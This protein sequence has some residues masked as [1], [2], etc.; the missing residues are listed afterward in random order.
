MSVVIGP[1]TLTIATVWMRIA[2]DVIS[3]APNAI[4]ENVALF[5]VFIVNGRMKLSSMMVRTWCLRTGIYN[6]AVIGLNRY[7][8]VFLNSILFVHSQR[9]VFKRQLGEN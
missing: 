1:I 9:S 8:F 7:P 3:R 4:A 2:L 5:A 6:D